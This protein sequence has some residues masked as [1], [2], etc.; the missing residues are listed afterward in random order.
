V[1]GY[2]QQG[3]AIYASLCADVAIPEME[4]LFGAR[5]ADHAPSAE[6]TLKVVTA[7]GD[8]QPGET[9][10]YQADS[11]NPKLWAATLDI[12]DGQVIAIDQDGRPALVIHQYG[13]GKTMLSTYPLEC[14]LAL[15]P[16]AFEGQGNTYRLYHAFSQWVGADA[17]FSTDH[18]MVE[19]AALA[20]A[21]RGYAILTNHSPQALNVKVSAQLSLMRI[22]QVTPSGFKEIKLNRRGWQITLKGF[23]GAVVEWFL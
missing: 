22:R 6:V 7:M 4:D 11:T 1:R 17:L 8:L 23:S 15:K 9:F 12:K 20:G 3:G 21:Q 19:V 5:L 2:V 18:P 16:A 10:Q 14:Y 13:K